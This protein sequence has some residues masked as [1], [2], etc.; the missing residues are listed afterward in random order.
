M[1]PINVVVVWVF[2]AASLSLN[3]VAVV[4][5]ALLA[6][7]CAAETDGK[8]A[9][10]KP[11]QPPPPNVMSSTGRNVTQMGSRLAAS[12][13]MAVK[14]LAGPVTNNATTGSRFPFP[15]PS[16]SPNNLMNPMNGKNVVTV[17]GTAGKPTP[18]MAAPEVV[19]A[20]S[21]APRQVAAPMPMTGGA[22]PAARRAAP[23]MSNAEVLPKG[24]SSMPPRPF[25]PASS[26]NNVLSAPIGQTNG[27]TANGM[28]P[29]KEVMAAKLVPAVPNPNPAMGP[30]AVSGTN[31]KLATN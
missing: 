20:N 7:T 17:N 12:D 29:A 4:L 6:L 10:G 14:P 11:V 9:T 28:A 21:V 24:T 22:M 19:K 8:M 27:M 15:Q 2:V 26:T 31:L 1:F 16:S 30:Q 3:F 25:S 5:M 18:V 13:A 23:E